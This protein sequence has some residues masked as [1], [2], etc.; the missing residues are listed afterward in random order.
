MSDLPAP[1]AL[2]ADPV[3]DRNVFFLLAL[4]A[5]SFTRKDWVISC[6]SIFKEAEDEWQKDPYAFRVVIKEGM[7]WFVNPENQT[8]KMIS[9]VTA[10]TPM[11]KMNDIIHL[12]A[13]NVNNLKTDVEST[14][15]LL[16]FNFSC[17]VYA[18]N[19]RIDY[20][21]EEVKPDRLEKQILKVLVD[22]PAVGETIKP[23]QITVSEY[24]I[25]AQMVYQLSGYSQLCVPSASP[26]TLT[27]HPDIHKLRDRLLE[28]NK[29]HL[30]DPVFIARINKQLEDLDREWVDDYGK[31]FLIKGK[32]FSNSR[33]KAHAMGGIEKPFVD[34]DRPVLVRT[35]LSEGIDYRKLPPM[36][37]TLRDASH[38]RGF[39]TQLGGVIAK[40]MGRSFQN[41]STVPEDCG[42]T[43]G[44]TFD[45]TER[46]FD[47]IVGFYYLDK[48]KP[49]EITPEL[50]AGMI[51]KSFDIRSPMVCKTR[52]SDHCA[53]CMGKENAQN[54]SGNTSLA[55]DIGS[56]I[57]QA[58][59]KRMHNTIIFVARYNFIDSIQ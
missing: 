2:L 30:E 58:S 36:I 17:L 31:D 51:G 52:F 13:N 39:Q 41:S 38:S 59:M 48:F 7:Y 16:L 47:T 24:L 15:G 23:E 5:H 12:K 27:H 4:H 20:I 54:P 44:L 29:D 45:V 18:F 34:G 22:D 53:I 37:N 56:V 50:K 25:F 3:V 43:V 33:L 57:M 46:N 21:N 6:F 26:K 14:I 9:G 1:N 10:A 42:S 49:V 32:S 19:D 35:S 40:V 11:F 8:L 55:T 28:E